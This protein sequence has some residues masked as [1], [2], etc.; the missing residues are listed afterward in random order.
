MWAE[1]CVWGCYAP[2]LVRHVEGHLLHGGGEH[3]LP[4]AQ[5]TEAAVAQVARV[6]RARVVQLKQAHRGAARHRHLPPAP[7]PPLD[8]PFRGAATGELG[9]L[10]AVNKGVGDK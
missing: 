3:H 5:D 1:A 2:E 10:G 9:D 7:S 4:V 6:Q 8:T